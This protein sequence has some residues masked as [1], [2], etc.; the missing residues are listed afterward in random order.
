VELFLP[1]PPIVTIMGHV[2]HGKNFALD[3]IRH[4]NIVAG[5]AGGITQHIAAYHVELRIK[6]QLL[7]LIP[8]VMKLLRQ[9]VP[10]VARLLIL[11][12]L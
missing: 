7:S 9:C 6:K 12:C 11:S 4:S 10:V 1:R 3:Y 2:D 8:R 5:E